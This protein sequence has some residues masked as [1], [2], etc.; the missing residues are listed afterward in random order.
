M[1][2]LGDGEKPGFR[3]AMDE[4]RRNLKENGATDKYAERKAAEVAKRIDR[5]KNR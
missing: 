5:Q 3:D 4:F 1:S 2:G